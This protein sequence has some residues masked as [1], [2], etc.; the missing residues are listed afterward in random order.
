MR[1]KDAK[2]VSMVAAARRR[3]GIASGII[4]CAAF[5]ITAFVGAFLILD[6]NTKMSRENVFTMNS[7]LAR[8]AEARLNK[9]ESISSRVFQNKQFIEYDASVYSHTEEY[10]VL[11]IENEINE[12]LN[13]MSMMDNYSD[14]FFLYA[15][16]HTVG[17]VS[18]AANEAF[19]KDMYQ[20]VRSNLK[21]KN[22]AWV[23]GLNGDYDRLYFVRNINQG[24]VFV[25][26]M[27]TNDMKTIFPEGS[28][29]HLSFALTDDNGNIIFSVNRN[30]VTDEA[31]KKLKNEWGDGEPVAVDSLKYA[32][33][34]DV[35]GDTWHVV[36]V[37]DFSSRNSRYTRILFYCAVIMA[38]AV[39]IVFFV[40][41]LFSSS[42]TPNNLIYRGDYTNNNVDRLTGLIMNEALENVI[43]GKIDRCIN[44]TTMVLLLVKIKNYEL[45]S[46]NYGESAV[47]EAL[48]KTAEVLRDFYGKNN[49]VGKT[50]D[51]EFAVLADF[52]DFNLFKAHDR[53]KANIRQLEEE[54]EKLELENERGMIRCAVGASV[55]PDDS[56]DYDTLYENAKAA[57]EDSAQIRACKC[58]YF[59]DLD[60]G[61][62]KQ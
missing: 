7:Q 20:K 36:S 35:C 1:T 32:A 19:G 29:E 40:G 38:G 60:K 61:K 46:E 28:A 57:L 51:N 3:T 6:Q 17:K 5:I 54:L 18:K 8:G 41:Y 11:R 22:S 33:S 12:F 21:N 4:I 59:S 9:L 10:E 45:I 2:A 52:T 43:I 49:T 13:T 50:G 25:S 44:G 53:M 47:D 15:N 24:T 27:F 14:F 48:L 30:K 58:R 31:V 26:S 39:I 56:D 55:Y 16:N 23:T 62:S 34:S 42:R 37:T